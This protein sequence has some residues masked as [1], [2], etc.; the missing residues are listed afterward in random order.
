MGMSVQPSVPTVSNQT[1]QNPQPNSPIWESHSFATTALTTF[2]NLT[3]YFSR[4]KKQYTILKNRKTQFAN[5]QQATDQHKTKINDIITGLKSNNTKKALENIKKDLDQIPDGEITLEQALGII[6][7]ALRSKI[8]ANT[9]KSLLN[10]LLETA[11]TKNEAKKQITE[12][13]SY[14]L[15]DETSNFPN[16]IKQQAIKALLLDENSD[17]ARSKILDDIFGKYDDNNEMPEP[18]LE[19]LKNVLFEESKENNDD[20]Q[21]GIELSTYKINE[22]FLKEL[23]NCKPWEIQVYAHAL[24]NNDYLLNKFKL[25]LGIKGINT[26]QKNIILYCLRNDHEWAKNTVNGNKILASQVTDTI[27]SNLESDNKS[28]RNESISLLQN[29][30]NSSNEIPTAILNLLI[31][32]ANQRET[33]V[34]GNTQMAD[35]QFPDWLFE[36]MRGIKPDTFKKIA[37]QI[38]HGHITAQFDNNSDKLNTIAT[39]ALAALPKD[40]NKINEQRIPFAVLNQLLSINSKTQELNGTYI[41]ARIGKALVDADCDNHT[42]TNTRT[43]TFLKSLNAINST[44]RE[45][46]QGKSKSEMAKDALLLCRSQLED[47]AYKFDVAIQ[48]VA[49]DESEQKQEQDKKESSA[50]NP[51]PITSFFVDCFSNA[52]NKKN[53]YLSIELCI[54]NFQTCTGEPLYQFKPQTY[55]RIKDAMGID[56]ARKSYNAAKN[57]TKG[58]NNCKSSSSSNVN[59]PADDFNTWYTNNKKTI[60]EHLN[61]NSSTEAETN[62][63]GI[64][65]DISSFQYQLKHFGE[66]DKS[67]YYKLSD[68]H[69]QEVTNKI[70]HLARTNKLEDE[71]TNN[72]QFISCYIL[73]KVSSQ[74]L[75]YCDNENDSQTKKAAEQ[76][77]EII[78]QKLDQLSQDVCKNTES[79]NCKSIT[80]SCKEINTEEIVVSS[81]EFLKDPN[82]LL[83]QDSEAAQ[84]FTE[85]NRELKGVSGH[86]NNCLFYSICGQKPENETDHMY[87]AY[88]LREQYVKIQKKKYKETSEQVLKTEQA[89]ILCLPQMATH[90]GRPIV[91]LTETT[92]TENIKGSSIQ[93]ALKDFNDENLQ[94]S[95]S[96]DIL[97]AD[98]TIADWINAS[99]LGNKSKEA[100]KALARAL[101]T[102]TNNRNNY[103]SENVKTKKVTEALTELLQDSNTIALH[104]NSSI[105]GGHYQSFVPK[106][107][108]DD[109]DSYGLV[110][111]F[112][113][114]T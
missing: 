1:V 30:I 2:K 36:V 7:G 64:T 29:I 103:T 9:K 13:F 76:A 34:A 71:L 32:A 6:D 82:P 87:N 92:G 27:K 20:N 101:N 108:E 22:N 107:H 25:E 113:E 84:L 31:G 96:E 83:Y 15:T 68:E 5:L 79:E 48:Y 57:N 111:L 33:S 95:I 100:F 105:N 78:S 53:P 43:T 112:E 81:Y 61:S 88:A 86:A 50:Q 89:E 56:Y 17:D 37:E 70:L 39:L 63:G 21:S 35:K 38:I 114:T 23:K 54:T 73:E 102:A 72:N 58:R 3:S 85:A 97:K 12:F 62:I 98:Q 49:D 51:T 4:D 16:E 66:I 40:D 74:L 42:W 26:W 28:T 44:E 60:F 67:R 69:I 77:L 47:N 109:Y 19:I 45:G 18:L 106:K 41:V 80:K 11:Q 110:S 52:K 90:L 104:L 93:I 8:D 91:V 59:D 55:N 75:D 14:V 65:L 46:G 99:G 24:K 94:L 10:M